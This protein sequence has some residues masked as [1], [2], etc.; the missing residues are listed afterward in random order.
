[1]QPDNTYFYV[2][3]DSTA[4]I[5]SSGDTLLGI[6]VGVP[7]SVV[8]FL[9]LLTTSV[10]IIMVLLT[11][12]QR[13]RIE[14]S[15]QLQLQEL[16]PSNLYLQRY[17]ATDPFETLEEYDIEYN[18]A[19]LEVVGELGEGAFGRVFKARA[20]GLQRGDYPQEEFVAV[21]TLKQ[22]AQ[23]DV[24]DS[25]VK[26]VKTCAQFDHVNVI[27]LLGV[28]TQSLQK[29]MIF[30]YMDL[31][32][33]GELL[34][35]SDPENPDY[36]GP[37]SGQVIITPEVFLHCILQLAQ[38]LTYL[39]T[40]KFIHRDIATRNCLINH[41]LVLK[42]ADFG[43]SREVSNMDYYRIGSAKAYLPVRWMP[44]EAL[45]YGK[46]TVKSDVWSFGVLMWEVYTFGHQPYSGISNYEV[47]D[48]IKT[49]RV[50]ECPELCP[51]SVYDIMKSCWTRVPSKRIE[52]SAVLTRLQQLIG[53]S[54][55][56][57]DRYVTIA[58]VATG[59]ANMLFGGVAKA[60]EIEENKRF[61]QTLLVTTSDTS[62]SVE[63]Q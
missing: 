23:S 14:I 19:S 5:T 27:R 3:D 28:C 24:L 34:R 48:R 17:Y 30:E 18:Y 1:M 57:K 26:E 52:M 41:N 36:P 13:K 40:L 16:A 53:H 45:L 44:P 49:G 20:P 11:R 62:D 38:G 54:A 56:F 60:S 8:I 6:Q 47:I 33:M 39:A 59:Y 25:F 10:I 9:L 58:P 43:L 51:A 7:I 63:E 12:R 42:I 31:G 21:K 35:L 55:E 61:A 50:L 37:K 4:V 22:D 15:Q 29:C 46:F 2:T 32:S